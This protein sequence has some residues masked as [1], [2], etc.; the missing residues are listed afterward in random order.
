MSKRRKEPSTDIIAKAISE[1]EP[2]SND[3]SLPKNIRNILAEAVKILKDEKTA[4][5]LRA[6][7]ALSL[8]EELDQQQKTPPHVLTIVY[9]VCAELDTV[10]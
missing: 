7:N 1:L 9:R 10:A 6:S 3:Q 4:P 2:L 5:Y 8:L